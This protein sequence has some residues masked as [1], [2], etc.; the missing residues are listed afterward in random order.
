[1][2]LVGFEGLWILTTGLFQSYL[3]PNE[4]AFL[5]SLIMKPLCKSS[6]M[7]VFSGSSYGLGFTARET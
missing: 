7:V 5:G 2:C 3:D 4:P 6:K 1:M